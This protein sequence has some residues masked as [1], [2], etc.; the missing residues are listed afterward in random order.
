MCFWSHSTSDKLGMLYQKYRHLAL[1]EVRGS[2]RLWG[3]GR[4]P[5]A[6]GCPQQGAALFTWVGTDSS[7]S[8]SST[9]GQVLP[10]SSY[11]GSPAPTWNHQGTLS[12]QSQTRHL[13][14]PP[15]PTQPLLGPLDP[16]WLL[17][18]SPLQAPT[19]PSHR[20]THRMPGP[21][22]IPRPIQDPPRD[23]R[24]QPDPTQNPLRDL[25][26]Q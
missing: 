15:A 16:A 5:G 11:E 24:S 6:E 4:V 10:C 13:T 1:G 20:T 23:P 18:G 7:R 3:P 22:R 21:S 25:R 9:R 2:L 12:S 19:P 26:S 17:M 14:E 8:T